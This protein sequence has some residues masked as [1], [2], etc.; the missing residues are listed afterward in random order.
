MK[1][2]NCQKYPWW[3]ELSKM[4]FWE[5]H[6]ALSYFEF[7]PLSSSPDFC[8]VLTQMWYVLSAYG[9]NLSHGIG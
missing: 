6:F 3:N 2:P 8:Y 5:S 7:T 9:V 1:F 4:T